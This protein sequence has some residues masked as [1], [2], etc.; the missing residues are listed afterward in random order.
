[1]SSHRTTNPEYDTLLQHILISRTRDSLKSRMLL[2]YT[3]PS[4]ISRLPHY[5]DGDTFFN[6]KNE[7]IDDVKVKLQIWNITDIDETGYYW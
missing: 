7:M 6:L 5:D 4:L 3:I 2:H 1:M